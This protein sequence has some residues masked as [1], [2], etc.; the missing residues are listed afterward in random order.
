[1]KMSHIQ[2]LKFASLLFLI[3]TVL[4]ITFHYALQFI[5]Q[6]NENENN[7]FLIFRAYLRAIGEKRGK[8]LSETFEQQ[9]YNDT[10]LKNSLKILTILARRLRSSWPREETFGTFPLLP[11]QILQI[12][13]S[14]NIARE[15]KQFRNILRFLT[16]IF[17]ICSKCGRATYSKM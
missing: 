7:M 11:P 2:S 12:T 17:Q 13:S 16:F 4:T 3:P 14:V 6:I 8:N 9:R 5:E 15:S 10:F 1:M